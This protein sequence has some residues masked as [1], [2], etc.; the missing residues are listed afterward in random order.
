VPKKPQ[1]SIVILV[2]NAFRHCFT[3]FRTLRRTDGVEYETVVVDNA[4][5]LPTRLLLLV[6]YLLGRIDKLCLLSENTLFS[7]GNNI[8]AKMTSDDATHIL[9]LNPDVAIRHPLWLKKIL[10]VHRRGGTGLDLAGG[11]SEFP[12]RADGFCFLVDRDLF[13]KYFLDEY[14]QHWWSL[15]KLEADLLRDAHS[16]QAIRRY[17]H[18]VHHRRGGSG[19][20]RR[21]A[22]SASPHTVKQWFEGREATVIENIE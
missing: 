16:V 4:S 18:L 12:T 20:V 2:Y 8:G 7:K 5:H 3:L 1:V 17:Q 22:R 10:A 13:L 6:L 11:G 14:Y 19:R 9:I 21:E 15:T